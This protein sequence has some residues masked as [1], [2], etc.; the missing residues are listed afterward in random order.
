VSS[1][2]CCDLRWL[3]LNDGRRKSAVVG[4]GEGTYRETLRRDTGEDG[5]D[6]DEEEERAEYTTLRHPIVDGVPVGDGVEVDEADTAIGEESTDPSPSQSG[7][8][9]IV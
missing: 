8:T 6:E 1:S 7:D 5:I 2:S 9:S 3:S 4:K